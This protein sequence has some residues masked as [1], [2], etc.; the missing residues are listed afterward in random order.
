M[1]QQTAKAWP[2]VSGI[3]KG[4]LGSEYQLKV[5]PDATALVSKLDALCLKNPLTDEDKGM[6]IGS[7]VRI[8]YL[9]GKEFWDL[10][11][12]TITEA[13]TSFIR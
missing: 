3:I 6:I 8:E 12:S 4:I 5:S 10:Y 13:L 11:G 1:Q 9:F 2:Y 7:I